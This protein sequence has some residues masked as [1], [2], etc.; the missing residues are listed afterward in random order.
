MRALPARDGLHV[1]LDLDDIAALFARHGHIA[2]AGEPVTQQEH[3]LQSAWLAQRDGADVALVTA[4]LL[5]DIGHLL[6]SERGS[7]PGGSPTEHGID[8]RHQSAALP[9]LRRRFGPAVLGPIALHVEAKRYLCV[10]RPGYAARLS[11]DSVRSLALQGGAFDAQQATR[12]A[13]R[14]WA[15]DAVRLRLWDDAAKVDGLQ[16][17]PL[18]HFLAVAARATRQGAGFSAA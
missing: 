6:A 2:Y 11:A 5:H 4:A 16:T 9:L 3:A 18:E 8:D 13:A 1:P 15:A 14:R 10:T 12:F 17:P 7:V